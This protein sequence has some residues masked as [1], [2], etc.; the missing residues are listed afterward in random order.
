MT[1]V[2]LSDMESPPLDPETTDGNA[3]FVARANAKS[4]VKDPE[5]GAF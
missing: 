4:R 1:A 5:P 3:E 2:A